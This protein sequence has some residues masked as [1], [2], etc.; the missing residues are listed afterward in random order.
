MKLEKK[1]SI[2]EHIYEKVHENAK[3]AKRFI[4]RSASSTFKDWIEQEYAP[5]ENETFSDTCSRHADSVRFFIECVYEMLTD[6][7]SEILDT[8]HIRLSDLYENERDS[9]NIDELYVSTTVIAVE[10]RILSP[11]FDYVEFFVTCTGEAYKIDA[12]VVELRENIRKYTKK[13]NIS[14]EEVFDAIESESNWKRP[15]ELLNTI[16]TL[17]QP[18]EMLSRLM[19]V[20]N[21]LTDTYEEEERQR[22][23]KGKDNLSFQPDPIGA[24]DFVPI[25]IAVIVRSNLKKAQTM[26]QMMSHVGSSY[27]TNG[28]TKYYLTMLESVLYYL[29]TKGEEVVNDLKEKIDMKKK[30]KIGIKESSFRLIRSISNASGYSSTNTSNTSNLNINDRVSNSNFDEKRQGTSNNDSKK[31]SILENEMYFLSLLEDRLTTLNGNIC[32]AQ[33]LIKINQRSL[34]MMKNRGKGRSHRRNSTFNK[35]RSFLDD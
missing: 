8:Y 20:M 21:A 30:K 34:L 9:D 25:L 29:S 12:K 33:S 31:S 14:I 1:N 11:I 7:Y 2:T 4:R 28:K 27:I 17:R 13:L 18:A 35:L 26:L 6:E 16:E 3:D 22:A 15:V 5:S 19:A 32:T 24:D 10:R 23:T